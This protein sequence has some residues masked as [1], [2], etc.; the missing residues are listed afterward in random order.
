MSLK[1]FDPKSI[2]LTVGG[3][4][5]GGFADGTFVTVERQEDAYTTTVGADGEVTRV[6][7]N[8]K[9]TNVTITLAQT[10]DSNSILSGFAILDEKSN[11]GVVPV[12]LKEAG[13]DTIV[14]G[15]RGW[16]QK[17]PNIEYSKEITTREWIIVL[18]ESEMFVGGTAVT[19]LVS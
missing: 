15:G 8:N 14:A 11:S 4:I 16:I 19:D 13:A 10:S 9:L 1:T 6:K 3:A 2:V 7:S 5:I 18:A 12:L 17:L